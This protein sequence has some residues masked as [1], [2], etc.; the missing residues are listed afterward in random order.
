MKDGWL[1]GAE[2]SEA[3]LPRGSS[4]VLRCFLDAISWASLR[5]PYS[6]REGS[7]KNP[8]YLQNWLA[9]PIGSQKGG[10]H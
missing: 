6:Q 9:W 10:T 7:G 3:A 2:A 5:I 8:G 4:C 1:F